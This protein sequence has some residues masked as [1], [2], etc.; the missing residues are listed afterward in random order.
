MAASDQ[1]VAIVTGGAVGIGRAI[2]DRLL[3]DGMAVLAVDRDPIAGQIGLEALQADI[4]TDDAPERIVAGCLDRFGRIDLLVN[5]AGRGA[6]SPIAETDDAMF[7]AYIGVNLR[8]GFRLCREALPALVEQC[9]AIVNIAS[10]L[11]LQGFRGQAAYS[12]AK[13]GV[14]G[15]TRQ[16][17]ADYAARGVRVNAVAPGVIATPMTAG[18]LA[19]RRFQAEIV[20]TTPMGRVGLPEEVAEAVAFLGTSRASFITGQVLAVDGGATATTYL[21]DA[22]IDRWA[23]TDAG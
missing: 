18:R 9:G 1:P 10:T 8:G 23:A 17:A 4:T 7:D 21:A 14:I 13:A 12:T 2:V 19:T 15:L 16:L 5:N 11:G 6:S 20:G 22:I 3:A